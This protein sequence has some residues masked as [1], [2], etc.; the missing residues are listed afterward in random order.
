MLEP[1]DVLE[2][3]DLIGFFSM[4]L[5]GPISRYVKATP[6]FSGTNSIVVKET[7]V[8]LVLSTGVDKTN[9][10]PYDQWHVVL[11][12]DAVGYVWSG[13]VRRLD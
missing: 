3:G 4:G 11:S 12:S 10:G 6:D 5:N 7:S 13:W 2:P 1:G 8:M 9:Y